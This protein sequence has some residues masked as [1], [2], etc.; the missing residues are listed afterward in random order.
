MNVEQIVDMYQHMNGWTGYPCMKEC[1]E[2]NCDE[3]NQ[4]VELK[5]M[6][7]YLTI[8]VELLNIEVIDEKK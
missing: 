1:F 6:E 7:K 5:E 8:A 2:D 4:Y 3:C